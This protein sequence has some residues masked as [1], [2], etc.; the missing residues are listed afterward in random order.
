MAQPLVK[1]DDDR[2]DEGTFLNFISIL[3][4]IFSLINSFFKIFN[5]QIWGYLLHKQIG[6]RSV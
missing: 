6:Y 3:R 2:D 5:Q 4:F 1:K